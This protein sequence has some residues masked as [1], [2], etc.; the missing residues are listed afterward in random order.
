SLTSLDN[1]LNHPLTFRRFANA[2]RHS[3]LIDSNNSF[4]IH[5]K[6]RR[7]ME[8]RKKSWLQLVAALVSALVLAGAGLAQEITGDIRG[9]VRDPSGAVVSGATVQ[10]IN[11]ERG[12]TERTIT[13]GPDGSYVASPLPVGR[14]QVVVTTPGFQKHVANNIVLNINDRRVVDAKLQ[15]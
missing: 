4:L 7:F 10:I 6:F 2:T 15:V 9:L 14:Y 1:G 11:T 3:K 13:T 5:K 12:R 8:V